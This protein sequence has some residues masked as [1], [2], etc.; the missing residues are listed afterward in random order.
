MPGTRSTPGAIVDWVVTASTA[1]NSDPALPKISLS[2]VQQY[3]GLDALGNVAS[4]SFSSDEE[5]VKALEM[6]KYNVEGFGENNL[7]QAS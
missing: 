6:L 1:I 4:E 7:A 3:T 5:C 2:I